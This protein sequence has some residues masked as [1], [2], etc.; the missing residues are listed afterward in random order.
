[1]TKVYI[2]RQGS[3]QRNSLA[4]EHRH[5]RDDETMNEPRAQEP[6]NRDST[7]D[8]DMFCTAR[9]E[10]RDDLGWSSAHL[11]NPGSARDGHVDRPA[12]QDHNPL[13]TIWPARK[14]QHLLEAIAT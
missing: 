11:F 9:G 10:L 14:G 7:V 4:D 3:E 1:M 13:L 2:V 5:P 6:L 8:V 12:A